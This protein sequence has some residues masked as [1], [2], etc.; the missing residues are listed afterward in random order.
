[1]ASKRELNKQIEELNATL[2]N[3]KN[4]V[5]TMAETSDMDNA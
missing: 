5:N 4:A 1:M 2:Q 3:I